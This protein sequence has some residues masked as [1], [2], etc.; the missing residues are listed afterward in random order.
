MMTDTKSMI[1]REISA[2]DAAIDG[3]L[4]GV[5]AGL[6]MVVYVALSGWAGGGDPLATLAL[7][8]PEPTSGPLVGLLAHLA[9]SGI[10]GV[11]FGVLYAGLLRRPSYNPPAWLHP[12]VGGL[13]GLLLL[14]AAWTL[15]LPATSSQLQQIPFAHL[16]IGHLV[17]GALLGWL[18][19]HRAR[20]A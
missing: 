17:Y 19:Y 13:Y 16:A 12:L 3:L 14:L 8:A 20:R 9:V 4:S 11:V 1:N 10:Y 18:V 5:I 15:L 2:S 6:V 7:F